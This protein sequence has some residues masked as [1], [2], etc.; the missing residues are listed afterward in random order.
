MMH[1]RY[2][3]PTFTKFA[4]CRQCIVHVATIRDPDTGRRVVIEIDGSPHR[5][6]CN[7]SAEY[8]ELRRDEERLAE[9]RAMKA[10]GEAV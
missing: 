8:R 10:R 3:V 4:I 6:R 7:G 2:D 9:L 5:Y 1:K